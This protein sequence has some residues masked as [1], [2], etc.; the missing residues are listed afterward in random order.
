MKLS[1]NLHIG[2]GR[3]LTGNLKRI[4]GEDKGQSQ[5]ACP[6]V[7]IGGNRRKKRKRVGR[8]SAKKY[9]GNKCLPS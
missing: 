8:R 3:S 5:I 1:G 9:R 7:A 4:A 2:F 6:K